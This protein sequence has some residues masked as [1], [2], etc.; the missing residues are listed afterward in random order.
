MFP[1]GSLLRSI[2]RKRSN[3]DSPPPPL[4]KFLLKF[5]RIELF[6]LAALY[7]VCVRANRFW[8]KRLSLR[9]PFEYP[10]LENICS[11]SSFDYERRTFCWH[12]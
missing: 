2:L 6:C 5:F 8:N 9:S 12:C 4:L 1:Y 3:P 7:R 11:E 10:L